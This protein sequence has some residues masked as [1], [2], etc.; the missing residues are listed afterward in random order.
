PGDVS[1]IAI[2]ATPTTLR[3]VRF[4]A[5][6]IGPGAGCESVG[7]DDNAIDC[8]LQGVRQIKLLLGEGDDVASVNPNVTVP[9][10]FRGG[11]GNDGPRRA[12]DHDRVPRP[13]DCDDTKAGVH[14]GAREVIGNSV[15]ENCDGIVVPFPPLTGSISGTWTQAGRGTR[16]RTLVAKGFPSRTV[17]SLR[18]TGSRAC[19]KRV[20]KT[21]RRAG[22]KLNL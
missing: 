15:D 13:Q 10:D 5:A 14:P 9:V 6:G 2:F 21:V 16:N 18:C 20:T 8:P 7:T 3:L 11:G 22:R 17:I 12:R 1:D 19:P 4:G